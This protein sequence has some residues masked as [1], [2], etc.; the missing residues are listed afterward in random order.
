VDHS[1]GVGVLDKS[2]AILAALSDGPANLADLVGRTGL[3]RPTAYRL[4]A[5][6]EAHRLLSR[7]DSGRFVL[8]PWLRELA[9]R[10]EPDR[11]RLIADGMLSGL[12]DA[13]GESTQLYRREGRF[14]RCV[15]SAEPVSGLR[16][17]VPVGALLP[18]TAG[19]GAQVLLAWETPAVAV[20]LLAAASFTSRTL[21]LVRRRGWASSAAEREAG[22]GSVSAP[23]RDADGY[24]VAAVS[25]SGP[26]DRVTRSPGRRH[27][28]AVVAAAESLRAALVGEG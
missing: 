19:S 6:L 2:A 9:V 13:T 5:A 11:L 26:L 10:D 12:R 3:A 8:G 20:P 15:A 21:A 1:S 23:V 25:V 14:R 18:M 24:V 27:A 7:D 22:V 16:D 17:F 4:A 28:D